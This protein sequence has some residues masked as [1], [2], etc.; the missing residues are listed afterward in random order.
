VSSTTKGSEA[1]PLHVHH[2][3]LD[4]EAGRELAR[5]FLRAE[6]GVALD[7]VQWQAAADYAW[8]VE[9]AVC[10]RLRRRIQ[11]L[12]ER[13]AAEIRRLEQAVAKI[14]QDASLTVWTRVNVEL[15][16]A[17]A[18]GVALADAVTQLFEE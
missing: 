9:H 3:V 6:E 17:R 10:T 16:R 4:R 13:N 11:Q 5:V 2:P 15:Q 14:D 8:A 1:G 12:V 7:D 18:A